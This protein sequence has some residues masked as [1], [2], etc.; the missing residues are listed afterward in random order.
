M[1][2][3]VCECHKPDNCCPYQIQLSNPNK[4]TYGCKDDIYACIWKDDESK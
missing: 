4:L 2:K 1:S 3:N